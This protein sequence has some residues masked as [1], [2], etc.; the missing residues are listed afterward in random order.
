M[1]SDSPRDK[2][3]A[4]AVGTRWQSC[5]PSGMA[6]TQWDSSHTCRELEW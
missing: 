6:V 3:E 4:L 1:H 2:G 5:D